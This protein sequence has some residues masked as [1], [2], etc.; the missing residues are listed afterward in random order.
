MKAPI[1]G[2]MEAEEFYRKSGL[3]DFGIG[4]LAT[5]FCLIGGRPFGFGPKRLVVWLAW[6]LILYGGVPVP[7]KY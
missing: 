1:E 5:S 3:C 4:W 6:F 2:R 7:R